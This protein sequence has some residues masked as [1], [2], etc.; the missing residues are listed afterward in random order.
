MNADARGAGGS[1]GDVRSWGSAEGEDGHDLVEQIAVQ[2]WCTGRVALAGNSWLAVSQWFIAAQ[3]PPHLT[4]IAPLEG[5]GDMLREMLV[6]GGV[7]NFGFLNMIQDS[8]PRKT[9]SQA[10]YGMIPVLIYG[11]AVSNKRTS[12]RCSQD[13]RT[14]ALTGTT[15]VPTSA[16]SRSQ[17][18]SWGATQQ[19]STLWVPSGL[20][21]RLR[22][23]RNGTLSQHDLHNSFLH[24]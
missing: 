20:M 5:S 8:L 6:R 23:S 16:R 12:W 4:A 22:M 18:T 24:D 19:I 9:S 2:P 17:P 7:P 15:N 13:T 3:Q 14:E 1:E 11:Q 10:R 21:T